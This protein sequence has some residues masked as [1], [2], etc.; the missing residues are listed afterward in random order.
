MTTGRAWAVACAVVLAGALALGVAM[1]LVDWL[2]ALYLRP[3]VASSYQVVASLQPGTAREVVELRLREASTTAGR[4]FPD[5]QNQ[6]IL[7][8]VVHY[9]VIEACG[10]TLRFHEGKLTELDAG[11]YNQPGPCPGGPA[12]WNAGPRAKDHVP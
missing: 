9:S 7:Y 1:E 8:F 3:K 4:M 6:N 11:D 10:F 12:T 5:Q 2:S